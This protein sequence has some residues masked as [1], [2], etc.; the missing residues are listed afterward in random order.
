MTNT[1]DICSKHYEEANEAFDR[2]QRKV[3][4]SK[5]YDV[6]CGWTSDRTEELFPTEEEYV[7]FLRGE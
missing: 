3:A 7:E 2:Y 5:G 1:I 6:K 4:E